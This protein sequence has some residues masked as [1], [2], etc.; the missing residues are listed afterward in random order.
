[1]EKGWEEERS[2]EERD[3][4][5]RES[6]PFSYWLWYHELSLLTFWGCCCCCW[7]PPPNIWSK[8]PNCAFTVKPQKLITAKRMVRSSI[9]FVC[10]AGKQRKT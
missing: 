1:M 6:I 7:P 2:I 4:E 3:K 5:G 9:I 10:N 8:K